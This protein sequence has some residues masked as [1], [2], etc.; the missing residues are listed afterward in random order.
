M[1]AWPDTA[2]VDDASFEVEYDPKLTTTTDRS[3]LGMKIFFLT[4][5][6]TPYKNPLFE[7]IANLEDIELFVGFCVW[8]SGTRPWELRALE[9]VRYEVLKGW[10]IPRGRGTY[11]RFNPA[12]V[13]R[14]WREAPDV[15]V[16]AG[17]NH[18]TMLLAVL[19][20]L[21][22]RTPFIMQGETWKKQV[23]WKARFKSW[24]LHPLLFR[25]SAFLVTG[26]L[27]HDYWVS[28]GYPSNRIRVFANTPDIEY[29]EQRRRDV[30]DD[31]IRELRAA[32]NSGNRRIAIFVG[33][34]IS[35]KGADLLLDAIRRLD[36]ADRPFLVMVGDGV[37][38]DRLEARA[39]GLPVVFMGFRSTDELIPLYAAAD[40]FILPSRREPWGVVVNEAMACGLPVVLSDQ[41]GS[42]ADLL[43]PS[44]SG[45]G[46]LVEGPS[47]EVLAESLFTMA[48]ID[49]VRLERMGRRSTE[50]IQNWKYDHSIEGLTQACQMAVANR[51]PQAI[52]STHAG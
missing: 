6:P 44:S 46:L 50:I 11:I 25:A 43:D 47:V 4:S 37:E 15:V 28:Q 38:R 33:R 12:V 45:N 49:D 14:L 13:S 23:G 42:H 5:A 16:I 29:F 30:T 32:W 7:G 35:V 1:C 10:H 17:Y 36:D 40:Y 3:H 9:G 22:T 34:F 41:V 19:Y 20:C 51:R 24:F 21:A 31:Q 27:A 48:R 26:R 39:R 2:A 52:R 8:K 18:P